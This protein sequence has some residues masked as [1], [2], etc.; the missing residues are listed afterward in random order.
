MLE[1]TGGGFLSLGRACCCMTVRFGMK[2]MA[3]RLKKHIVVGENVHLVYGCRTKKL[4]AE[5]W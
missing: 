4:Y 1:L 3:F 2:S 5:I